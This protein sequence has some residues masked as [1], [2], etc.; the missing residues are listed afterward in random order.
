MY[1]VPLKWRIHAEFGA[2]VQSSTSLV[3]T[4]RSACVQMK[5]RNYYFVLRSFVDLMCIDIDGNKVSQLTLA[6]PIYKFQ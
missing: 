1:D 4:I 5:M 2:K 3:T 6:P